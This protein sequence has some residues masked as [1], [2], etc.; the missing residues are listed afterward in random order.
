MKCEKII[1]ER[2]IIS[3]TLL[4]DSDLIYWST[5][6]AIECSYCDCPEAFCNSTKLTLIGVA[7]PPF[8]TKARDKKNLDFYGG[9]VRYWKHCGIQTVRGKIQKYTL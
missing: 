8:A 1:A 5:D 7:S 6:T 9:L 3:H 2:S 4:P